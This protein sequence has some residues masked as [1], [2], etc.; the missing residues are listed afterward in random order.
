MR[1]MADRQQDG[2]ACAGA[3]AAFGIFGR[4]GADFDPARHPKATEWRRMVEQHPRMSP[5]AI[6]KIALTCH[7]ATLTPRAL[8]RLQHDDYRFGDVGDD[9]SNSFDISFADHPRS[10]VMPGGMVLR[11]GSFVYINY[12][13]PYPDPFIVDFDPNLSAFVLVEGT[14]A[15]ALMLDVVDFTPRPAIFG[16]RTSRGVPMDTLVDVR[17]QKLIFTAFRTCRFWERGEQCRF[18][19]FF[20]KEGRLHPEVDPE[21]LYETVHAALEEPGRFS[22]LYLSGGTD[23][24]GAV[25][26]EVEV[27]RYIRDL[28]AMGRDF[29]G[30][31]PCQLM[32]P[33][34]P[35]ALLERI[36]RE[37]GITAYSA[38]IEVWDRDL[39]AELC[40]GK[41]RL[42]GHDEWTRRTLDAVEVF[43]R[44]NV[45]TQV[46]AGVELARP[47]GFA[48]QDEALASNLEACEYFA[49]HG[50]NCLFIIWRPH[51]RARLGMQPMAPV[52]YYVRLAEGFHEIRR[53]HGLASLDDDY[54]MCGNHP[55]ADLERMDRECWS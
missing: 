28:Q 42:V 26:H 22:E 49:E 55:C 47:S 37:T 15:D 46:V 51:P 23:T 10:L 11:D 35:K 43:G 21:D 27:E 8:E 31:F 52:D 13:D 6:L 39:F 14:G 19:A 34:Y 53:A 36:W 30:R 38:D 41:E 2:F 40:P 17:P 20:T 9:A 50:V 4:F 18:C 29:T 5:F 54:K 16:R 3:P 45:Y 33:A 12:G 32:A 48:T 25:P 1:D 24:A 44:G 7:G